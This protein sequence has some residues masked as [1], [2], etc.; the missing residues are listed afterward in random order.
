MGHLDRDLTRRPRARAEAIGYFLADL[1]RGECECDPVGF[2]VDRGVR[3]LEE[4]THTLPVPFDGARDAAC[5]CDG[6][7][8]M[9]WLTGRRRYDATRDGERLQLERRRHDD[10]ERSVGA[11]KQLSEVITGNVLD[12]LAAG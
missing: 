5:T 2:V 7:P 3:A 10:A 4:D 12:H 6:C 9:A 11:G 1:G 8:C